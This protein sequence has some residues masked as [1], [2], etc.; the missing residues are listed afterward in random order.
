VDGV[1]AKRFKDQITAAKEF[2]SNVVGGKMLRLT[3][4]KIRGEGAATIATY[5]LIGEP[6]AAGMLRP[7]DTHVVGGPLQICADDMVQSFQAALMSRLIQAGMLII[8]SNYDA[9][10]IAAQ[11]DTINNLVQ[12][13]L[14]PGLGL[15]PFA[16]GGPSHLD[17]VK[18]G[19]LLKL[20]I[21][22]DHV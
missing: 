12:H 19:A 16:S 14:D 1:E 3:G 20:S 6:S 9:A 13:F 22:V 2:W 8:S 11:N 15:N 21:Q 4:D 17:F 10:F 7:Q 18:D 5:W